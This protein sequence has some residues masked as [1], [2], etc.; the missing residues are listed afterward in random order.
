MPAVFL[1]ALEKEAFE[2]AEV[3]VG[4][5][6]RRAGDGPSV[7]AVGLAR[8]ASPA[9]QGRDAD[10]EN[11]SDRGGG[12]A[13]FDEFHGAATAAFQFSGCSFGSHTSIIQPFTKEWCL[14]SRGTQ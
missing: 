3:V 11:A 9:V 8:H 13:L 14:F 4:Q 6:R 10:A 12:F 7:E 2:F 5:P 1:G